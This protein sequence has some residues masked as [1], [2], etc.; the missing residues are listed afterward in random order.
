LALK[1]AGFWKVKLPALK[2]SSAAKTDKAQSKER[3][4]VLMPRADRTRG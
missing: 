3:K 4:I 2:V 1:L